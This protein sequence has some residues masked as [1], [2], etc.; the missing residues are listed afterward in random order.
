[1]SWEPLHAGDPFPADPAAIE[2]YGADVTATAQLIAEQVASL[3]RLADAN[4]WTTDTAD[5]FRERATDTANEIEK[6]HGR[7]AG[8][9]TALTT[10]SGELQAHEAS[11]KLKVQEAAQLVRTIQANPEVS[12]TPGE[13]GA[14]PELSPEGEAQNARR[15]AAQ[16]RFAELQTEFH[17]IVQAAEADARTC[18]SKI[19]D[20]KDDSVK[21]NW[22]ERNAGWLKG[23]ATVLGA[24]AAV[25]GI[26]LLTVA[27]AGTIW[28]VV[29]VVAGIA[30]LLI[31][32]GLAIK[33]DG[34]WVD[35]AFDAIGL[36]TLG[37]GSV[38]GRAVQAAWKGVST[39]VAAAR[40]TKA[41][42]AVI[43]G[44]RFYDLAGRITSF[45][46]RVFG[47]TIPVRLPIV[48]NLARGYREAVDVRAFGAAQEAWHTV[49]Q[50]PRTSVASRVFWG[51]PDEAGL[52]PR[53]S[54]SI[55]DLRGM[56]QVADMVST[57]ESARNALRVGAA[58]NGVGLVNDAIDLTLDG[59]EYGSSLLDALRR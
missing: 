33:A 5:A 28:L 54:S 53:I 12:P 10:L 38:I 3:R 8:V 18:E 22:W 7:Y 15:A 51:G 57:L 13:D 19:N 41:F 44:A 34:S 9:G 56:P 50:A 17:Q 45:S 23:L 6:T 39:A 20:A 43:D 30:A 25:A 59:A 48:S 21:D 29:A 49:M 40:S 27:T 52:I 46:V 24:I 14:P 47:R 35:V 2:T 32:L 37:A 55:D 1:M 42:D 16:Q 31:N 36:L 26:I 11:A 4:N 58:V